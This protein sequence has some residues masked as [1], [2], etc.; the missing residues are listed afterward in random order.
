[1]LATALGA[2]VTQLTTAAG[3]LTT[4]IP[5]VAG[6]G[7]GIGLLAFGIRYIVHVFKSVAH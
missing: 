2:V 7:I 5:T 3:D 1:M 6:V 4:V